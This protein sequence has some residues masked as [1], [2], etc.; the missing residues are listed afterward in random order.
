MGIPNGRLF[1]LQLG[2]HRLSLL[3]FA[4]DDAPVILAWPLTAAGLGLD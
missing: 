3:A 1:T 2:S 4:N